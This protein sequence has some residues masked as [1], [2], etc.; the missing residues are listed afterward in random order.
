M[1]LEAQRLFIGLLRCELYHRS[2]RHKFF[3][4]KLGVLRLKGKMAA[5]RRGEY[6]PTFCS[7][8]RNM[9]REYARIAAFN[10]QPVD[11]NESPLVRTM[12]KL[13]A[14][15]NAS[16]ARKISAMRTSYGDGAVA[17][18]RKTLHDR[19]LGKWPN[20]APGQRKTCRYTNCCDQKDDDY[21]LATGEGV[22][23]FLRR[24]VR[25][26]GRSSG[27]GKGGRRHE[28]WTPNACG[29]LEVKLD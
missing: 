12:M 3:D 29:M 22:S 14:L 2:I 13:D 1:H 25:T 10:R 18:F 16:G 4:N 6:V 9:L 19:R 20:P 26:L 11:G 8:P 21:R 23:P 28:S 27:I 24:P 7:D 17:G 15:E 5:K